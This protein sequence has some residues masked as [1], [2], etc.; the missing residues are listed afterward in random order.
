MNSI[1]IVSF[2]K[3][4]NDISKDT[5]IDIRDNYSYSL[6]HI[7]NAININSNQLLNNPKEYLS[8]NKT[9]YIYCSGGNNSKRV[10]NTL[11]SFG[12]NTINIDGGYD[13]YLLFK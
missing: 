7:P 1:D 4:I 8:F 3:K 5:I 9:Y 6:G 12:Y 2:V 11:N 13:M 10:V